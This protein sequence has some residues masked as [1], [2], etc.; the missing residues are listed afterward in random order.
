[1]VRRGS[2]K[3][4]IDVTRE[5]SVR[6]R[7]HFHFRRR[8]RLDVRKFAVL[9]EN[10]RLHGASIHDPG[11]LAACREIFAGFLVHIGS[12]D[13]AVDRRADFK[14]LRFFLRYRQLLLKPA[15]IANPLGRLG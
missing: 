12:N 4:F 2:W 8:A 15:A 10:T 9:Y 3:Y 7:K 14:L 5:S 6:K 11:K 1:M 13:D